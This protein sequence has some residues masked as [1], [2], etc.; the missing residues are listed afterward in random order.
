MESNLQ[1]DR[2]PS[3]RSAPQ[4]SGKETAIRAPAKLRRTG[5]LHRLRLAGFAIAALA[6]LSIVT[7]VAYQ[8]DK[9]RADA[10]RFPQ[11][12]RSVDIGGYK[13]NINCKGE[14]SPTVILEA[15]LGVPA[16]SWRNVQA[17]IAKFTRVCSYD[18]A[19]Y[20]WSDP[21]P[22]PRTTSQVVKELHTLLLNAGERP[23]YILVGHSFGGNPVRIYAS[24]YPAEVAG[25]VLAE[26]GHE[27][28]KL[29]ENFQELVGQELS[30]RRSS[31]RWAQLLYWLGISRFEA[32]MDIEN[33]A[34]PFDQQEW[35]YFVLKPIFKA[36]AIGEL[37]TLSEANEELRAAGNLGDKPLIVLI[38][39]DLRFDLPLGPEEEADV[40]GLRVD[41]EKR[42]ALLSTRGKWVMVS[43]T[44][45]MIPFE[46]P[47]SIVNAVQEL[48]VGAPDR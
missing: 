21:G 2:V 19:G 41:F 10:R 29:P 24:H 4:G 13:L 23:P 11:E 32:R 20:D 15:G 37:E 26:T 35:N 27:D 28:L 47:D 8:F 6:L 7:G 34:V 39:S 44:S 43:G 17:G 45:H 48:S 12:G 18:R 3:L 25:I 31:Q 40:H 30:R 36:T 5:F 42:L 1:V 22:M 14:G 38:A 16:I 9:L 46:R 33:P